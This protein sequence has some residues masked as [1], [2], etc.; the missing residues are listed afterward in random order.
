MT[1]LLCGIEERWGEGWW[2]E[3][4]EWDREGRRGR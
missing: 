3:E 4:E 2:V 1:F